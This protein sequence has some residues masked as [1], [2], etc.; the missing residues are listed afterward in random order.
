V[1]L[2]TFFSPTGWWSYIQ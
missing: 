2:F 1:P